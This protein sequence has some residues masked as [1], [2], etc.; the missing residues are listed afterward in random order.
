MSVYYEDEYSYEDIEHTREGS[1]LDPDEDPF[2]T[3]FITY[4]VKLANVFEA[5]GASLERIPGVSVPGSRDN[6][7]HFAEYVY[8]TFNSS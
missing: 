1:E 2:I 3:W 4:E 7:Q 5:M 8:Y 6:L